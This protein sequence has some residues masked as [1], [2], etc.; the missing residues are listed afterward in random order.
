MST[1]WLTILKTT[2]IYGKAGSM[3]KLGI[4]KLQKSKLG[5]YTNSITV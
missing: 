5:H 3:S 2:T 1:R 4:K